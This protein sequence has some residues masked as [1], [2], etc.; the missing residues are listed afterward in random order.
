M[1][2]AGYKNPRIILIPISIRYS[3]KKQRKDRTEEL[4]H[5]TSSPPELI[6]RQWRLQISSTHAEASLNHP[7][8]RIKRSNKSCSEKAEAG[9]RRTQRTIITVQ[10]GLAVVKI[11]PVWVRQVAPRVDSH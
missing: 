3:I 1:Y 9:P 8:Q 6:V 10:L 11:V 5:Q 2:V 4:S 7:R